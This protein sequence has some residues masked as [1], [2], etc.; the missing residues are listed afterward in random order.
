M[1]KSLEALQRI[2]EWKCF[3]DFEL[4]TN[5]EAEFGEELKIIENDLK[6]MELIRTRGIEIRWAGAILFIDHIY[7]L[8]EE[9]ENIVRRAIINGE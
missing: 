9:E 3:I 7:E 1:S 2:R 4:D 8:T 6:A 5:G